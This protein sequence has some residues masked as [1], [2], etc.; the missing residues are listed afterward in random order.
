MSFDLDHYVVDINDF[1]LCELLDLVKKIYRADFSYLDPRLTRT[2]A[3]ITPC[4]D[5]GIRLA[6]KG[7]CLLARSINENQP[8]TSQGDCR[9]F[10]K[11]IDFDP[12]SPRGWQDQ[13]RDNVEIFLVCAAIIIDLYTS[14]LYTRDFI[15]IKW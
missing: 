14:T 6:C 8:C 12:R 11:E 9:K 2:R 1:S 13:Y 7:L 4:A 15:R 5:A 10:A 3:R